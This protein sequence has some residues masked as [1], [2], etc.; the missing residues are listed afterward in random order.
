MNSGFANAGMR[1]AD[2]FELTTKAVRSYSHKDTSTWLAV[3]TVLSRQ[4]RA[5]MIN[6]ESPR[7]D[8]AIDAARKASL[9]KDPHTISILSVVDDSVHSAIFTELPLG[10]PVSRFL[11]EKPLPINVSMAIIGQVASTLNEARHRGIRYLHLRA[12]NIYV[13]ETNQ[14]LIDGLGVLPAL[15]EVDLQRESTEL[16]RAEARGLTV[17]FAALL[18]GQDF[19]TDAE[20][21]DSVIASAL[22]LPELPNQVR[23][24]FESE[25]G[26]AELSGPD[27]PAEFMRR[28]APWDLQS[29]NL[30]FTDEFIAQIA[31][32]RNQKQAIIEENIE[33]N[34]DFNEDPIDELSATNQLSALNIEVVDEPL[35]TGKPQWPSPFA[36]EEINIS[37]L[38]QGLGSDSDL[39]ETEE[40]VE[41]EELPKFEESPELKESPEL[42]ESKTFTIETAIA[43]I[44]Q[45]TEPEIIDTQVI[46]AKTINKIPTISETDSVSEATSVSETASIPTVKSFSDDAGTRYNPT[47]FVVICFSILMLIGLVIGIVN[48]FKPLDP[49]SIVKN[50]DSQTSSNESDTGSAPTPTITND[51][52]PEI[53][54]VEFV[55]TSGNIDINNPDIKVL[56]DQAKFIADDDANTAW[57]SWWY[58]QQAGYQAEQYGLKISLKEAAVVSEISLSS[59]SQGGKISIRNTT[60]D[61]KAESAPVLAEASFNAEENQ[62]IKIDNP[63][64][65][66]E[67][68]LWIDEMPQTGN[69]IQAKIVEVN[70]K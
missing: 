34:S 66:S 19:P 8:S 14:V 65:V 62:I 3:D 20:T 25:L 4:L 40:S 57:N 2:R 1:I 43:E 69:Q 6:P 37:D 67:L 70:V 23:E 60:G 63:V 41:I 9:L 59:A 55:N 11:H 31:A 58:R 26:N 32:N 39:I 68:T 13:T 17:F 44:P 64:E 50:P 61:T 47:K 28:I 24:L 16:D 7:R 30:L 35:L 15:Y 38:E 51:T 45:S 48:L 10:T 56:V 27:S 52:V 5:I 29:L 21:H 54:S 53:N 46:D 18:Q 22:E 42:A 33:I 49:V 36:N 12:R